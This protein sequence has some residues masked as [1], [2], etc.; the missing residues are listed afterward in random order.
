M[1]VFYCHKRSLVRYLSAVLKHFKHRCIVLNQFDKYY[2]DKACVIIPVGINAQINLSDYP[3]YKDKF[4]IS[5]EKIYDILDDKIL[6]YKYVEKYR[7]LD[8]TGIRLIPTYTNTDVPDRYGKFIIKKTSGA[9]SSSNHIK[10]NYLHKLVQKYGDTH[11]IQ[12]VIDIKYV[13]SV[14]CLC[15]RGKLLTSINFIIDGY[16]EHSFYEKN[17]RMHVRDVK[18]KIKT[19]IQ[20]IAQEFRYSGLIEVE[21]IVSKDNKIYLMECNPRVSSNMLCMENDESVPFNETLLYPYISYIHGSPIRPKP[22][23]HKTSILYHGAHTEKYHI[24][25]GGIIEFVF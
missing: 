6:F 14:N 8:G 12:D 7:L 15:A 5:P 10:H 20:N 4:L 18:F 3:E 25:D 16:I 21:F 11:Q 2:F 22:Y 13:Y 1:I 9:G 24:R 17:M 23:K 19:V